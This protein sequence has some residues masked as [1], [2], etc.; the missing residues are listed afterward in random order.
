MSREMFINDCP[1]CRQG[2]QKIVFE[3]PTGEF[4]VECDECMLQWES[5]EDAA[6]DTGRCGH[7]HLG[8][9]RDATL[10]EIQANGWEKYIQFMGQ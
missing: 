7:T 5:V 9:Q 3:I 1:F 2:I 8:E 6:R 4:F 10:E